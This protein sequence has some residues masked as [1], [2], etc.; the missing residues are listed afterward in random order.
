MKNY[1]Q[2]NKIELILIYV[3]L[4]TTIY[5]I[6]LIPQKIEKYFRLNDFISTIIHYLAVFFLFFV[7]PS[8][9]IKFKFKENLKCYGFTF[10]NFLKFLKIILIFLPFLIF[11]IWLSSFQKDFQTE[12][13]LAKSIISQKSKIFVIE[14]FYLLYYIGWEFLFRG[15]L[16]FGLEKKFGEKNAIFIQTIISVLLHY[17]KP[18]GEIL[19]ALIA[20]I[21]LGYFVRKYKT[22]F[23][24][25]LIHFIAGISMDIF[26]I[27]NR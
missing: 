7:I 13:P 12:Y 24:A 14:L 4:V 19:L 3:A 11:L 8:L 18:A 20:G 6:F 16:L 15:F 27:F 9:I 21:L 22:I 26:V 23:P 17:T 25:I 5:P 1:L 10:E 2:K